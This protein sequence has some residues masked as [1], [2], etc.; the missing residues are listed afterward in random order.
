[1]PMNRRV[2]PVRLAPEDRGA[3]LARG[4]VPNARSGAV[5]SRGPGR[6]SC[7]R[8]RPKV[9]RKSM[10]KTSSTQSCT[11]QSMRRVRR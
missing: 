8:L 2:G 3:E 4:E 7:E 1:M 11:R 9:K 6:P 5:E 10:R